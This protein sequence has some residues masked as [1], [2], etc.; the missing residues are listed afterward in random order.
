M[1]LKLFSLKI[2]E[3]YFPKVLEFFLKS[4]ATSKIL[5]FKTEIYLP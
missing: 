2:H 3:K 5:P 4:T 1:D